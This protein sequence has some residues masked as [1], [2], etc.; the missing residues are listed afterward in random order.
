MHHTGTELGSA[1]DPVTPATG[2]LLLPER[3]ARLVHPDV[4]QSRA[5]VI[6]ERY[7]Q[8]GAGSFYRRRYIEVIANHL[9]KTLEN[10]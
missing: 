6:E 9:L 5:K 7:R 1:S 2:P 8:R 4:L 3:I 10:A